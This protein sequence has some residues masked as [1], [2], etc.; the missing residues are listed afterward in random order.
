MIRKLN[1]NNFEEIVRYV[2]DLSKYF[3]ENATNSLKK[4]YRKFPTHFNQ[5]ESD[6]NKYNE[7]GDKEDRGFLYQELMNLEG[8]RYSLQQKLKGVEDLHQRTELEDKLLKLSIKVIYL[9]AIIVF[10]RKSGKKCEMLIKE[11][12]EKES[13]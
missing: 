13:K 2:E 12:L 5:L 8:I 6:F 3:K 7:K 4:M 1:A 10:Y 9:G 11:L